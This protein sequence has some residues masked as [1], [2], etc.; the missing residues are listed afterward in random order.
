[1]CWITAYFWSN[2]GGPHRLANSAKRGDFDQPSYS[3]TRKSRTVRFCSNQS[4]Y[5]GV[6]TT[7]LVG[8]PPLRNACQNRGSEGG[9]L[10]A[11]AFSFRFSVNSARQI[12][13]STMLAQASPNNITEWLGRSLGLTKAGGEA[14]G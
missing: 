5:T 6:G 8:L 7:T 3:G 13:R 14:T 10:G 11:E 2:T 1:M 9:T 12:R 4:K